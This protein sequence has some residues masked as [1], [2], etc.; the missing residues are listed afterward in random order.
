VKPFAMRL[1]LCI[2]T[3]ELKMDDNKILEQILEELRGL[4]RDRESRWVRVIEFLKSV[5]G[6]IMGEL[7]GRM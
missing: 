6:H 2:S 1:V 5:L 7:K 4:R 3:G